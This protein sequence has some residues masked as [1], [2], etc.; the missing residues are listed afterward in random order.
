VSIDIESTAASADEASPSLGRALEGIR[1]VELCNYVAG[2]LVGLVLA[3][4]GAEVIKI[5]RLDGGDDGRLLPPFLDGD[6]YFFTECNRNKESVALDVRTD[7]GRRIARELILRA[8]IVLDNFR[9]GVMERLGFGYEAL[10]AENPGLIACSVTGFG[11]D[12]AYADRPGYDPI[13]QAMSGLML[14]TGFPDDPPVRVGPSI[15]DKTAAIWAAGTVLAALYQREKT[16]LGQRVNVSLLAAAVH[17]MTQDIL[18]HLATGN[19]PRRTGGGQGA[20]GGPAGSF[21]AGDGKYVQLAIG[22][23]RLYAKFCEAVGHPELAE[24]P[25]FAQMRDRVANSDEMGRIIDDLF[26]QQPAGH[27][28]ELL[29]GAGIPC[30]PVNK[31]SEFVADPEVARQF[32]WEIGRSTGNPVPQVRTPL[33]LLAGSDAERT[34]PPVHGEHTHEVLRREFG[35]GDEQIASLRDAGVVH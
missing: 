34:A 25:K 12:N 8:D 6:G 30:G 1:V 16:G 10:R 26:S 22:N 35:Y 17:I 32:I 33:S 28:V 20:R 11:E 29:I 3:D 15:V 21:L 19:E 23:D 5:E 14:V 9:N 7:E 13:L 18:T 24:D 27:W 4:L 31:V 2:P